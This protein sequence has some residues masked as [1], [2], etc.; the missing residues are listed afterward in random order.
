MAATPVP[1]TPAGSLF[2][3]RP[4]RRRRYRVV[5]VTRGSQNGALAEFMWSDSIITGFHLEWRRCRTFEATGSRRI[6]VATRP[7]G[8][9]LK[10]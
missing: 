7:N 5:P 10:P 6:N 8:G 4:R 3:G 9:T 1:E 2:S